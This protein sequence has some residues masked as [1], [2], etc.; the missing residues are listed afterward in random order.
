MEKHVHVHYFALLR[1]QRGQEQEALHTAAE[2]A[3][4][5]CPSY[6]SAQYASQVAYYYAGRPRQAL[7]AAKAAIRL[8]PISPEIWTRYQMLAR[9][10]RN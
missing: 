4:E 1:E 2:T 7:A 6:A 9:S 5:L 3:A 8:D 10:S